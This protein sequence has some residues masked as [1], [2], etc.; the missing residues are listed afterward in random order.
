MHAHVGNPAPPCNVDFE[1]VF[2]KLS[3][4]LTNVL[5]FQHCKNVIGQSMYFQF[6]HSNVCHDYR[7]TYYLI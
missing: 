4:T 1:N 2:D 6:S 7:Y 3:F 5:A